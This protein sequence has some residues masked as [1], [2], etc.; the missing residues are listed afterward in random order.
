MLLFHLLNRAARAG[1]G[2]LPKHLFRQS[3]LV[4]RVSDSDLQPLWAGRLTVLS[5]EQHRCDVS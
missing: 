5:G 2:K 4:W 3:E 1:E